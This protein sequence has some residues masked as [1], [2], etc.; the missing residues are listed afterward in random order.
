MARTAPDDRL[1]TEIHDPSARAI[2][3]ALLISLV[4]VAL[5]RLPLAR[6]SA[7]EFDE[8]GYLEM[9]RE[10]HFPMYHTLFLAA[11]RVLGG[12]IGDAYRGF[13]VL[14]TFVSA[15]ALVAV[16]WWLRALV[17]PKTAAA[18]A[19]ALGAAPVFWAYGAMAGNYTAIPLVGSILLGVAY[20]GRRELRPGSRTSRPWRWRSEPVTGRTSA[21]SGCRSSW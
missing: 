19:V 10:T 21:R 4:A 3:L 8:V 12:W 13:V 5:T 2:A 16:W 7:F 11:S 15:L 1:G 14:D 18:G 6:P 9:I 17:G 20:R